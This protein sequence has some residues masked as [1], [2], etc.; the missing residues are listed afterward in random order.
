[1]VGITTLNGW[2]TSIPIGCFQIST[3]VAS[4]IIGETKL[5]QVWWCPILW[6]PI[7]IFYGAKCGCEY[8]FGTMFLNWMDERI[9][10]LLTSQLHASQFVLDHKNS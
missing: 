7:S 10:Q 1:V 6:L 9:C 3:I 2:I 4:D 5:I 8:T